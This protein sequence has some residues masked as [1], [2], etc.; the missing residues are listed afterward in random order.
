MFDTHLEQRI[1]ARHATLRSLA[2]ALGSGQFRL[3]YQPKVDCRRGRIVGAEALIRWQHPTLGLLSPAEFIP[4]L[5]DADLAVEVGEWVIR[6]ALSQIGPWRRAGIDFRISVNAFVHHLLQPGFAR[7]L[8][9]ILAQYPETGPACLQIEIVETAALKEL[10]TIRQVMEECAKLGVTFS[11]DD[12]G[13]GY[14]TLAHLRHLPATEIKIDQSFVRHML[15][16]AEDRA[17]VE[18]MIGMGRAFGRCV[19]AE[20]VET[21]AHIDCLLALGC[22]VMQG[23][24][25]ARPMPAN[26]FSRWVREFRP[27]PAWQG[28][29][30]A[31]G[32][33]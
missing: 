5:E 24:A 18:A 29:T 20:G 13:T 25:L 32:K 22:D 10:D 33:T 17:I 15:T 31:I 23:Y 28:L 30:D 9:V 1:A 26:D 4:L 7:A 8:A 14:S 12:F 27:N 11:L 19:V 6:E 21:A 16:R 3:Y 2:Q